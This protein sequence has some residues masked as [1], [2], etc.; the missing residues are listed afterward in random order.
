MENQVFS[1][2]MKTLEAINAERDNPIDTSAGLQLALYGTNGVFDSMGLVNFLST[3][4]EEIE[5]EMDQ[6]VS[7]TSEKAVSRKISPFSSVAALI[8]FIHEELGVTAAAETLEAA[9]V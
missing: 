2:I 3:L 8:D 1:L 4:E 9:T 5:D 6:S 7:L